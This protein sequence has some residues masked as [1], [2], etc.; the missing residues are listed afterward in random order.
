[1]RGDVDTGVFRAEPGSA[2]RLSEHDTAWM[3]TPAMR[4]L[5]A[6]ELKEEARNYVA[7]CIS[8]FSDAQEL[9]YADNRYSMLLL[10]Q[11]MD[12]A[13]KDGTIK[14]VTAGVNPAGFQVSNFKQPSRE[15][16]DHNFLWRY[17]KAMP[18][19]GR[20][21][22]FNRSYY[23]DVTTVRVHPERGQL[24]FNNHAVDLTFWNERLEDI[25][26]LERHL[27]RNGTVII[28]F[29]LNVSKAEQ[30]R[31]LIKRLEDPD[32]HWKYD[33]SDLFERGYWDAYVKAFD[34]ALSTTSTAW[35]P[36]YIV[37]AD[38]KWVMR[39][40][41]ASI[42]TS[43]IGAMDLAYPVQDDARHKLLKKAL[44]TLTEE[45]KPGERHKKKG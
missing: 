38:H 16:L 5:D 35:A 18:E 32:K 15:E 8:E 27:A 30:K 28:K 41:V 19:R 26:N 44:A 14:H 13:G 11:G 45:R 17:W 42:I 10:F 4:Q 40:L 6:D 9:L 20:I 34:A 1:M 23:E 25:N 29:F 22:I 39:A 12:A 21:G 43:H 33:P 7:R 31:R 3:G 36:W 24:S 37:P 2:I